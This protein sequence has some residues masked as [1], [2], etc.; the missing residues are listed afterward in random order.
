MKPH[1]VI[2]SCLLIFSLVL[3]GCA[4][5][6]TVVKDFKEFDPTACLNYDT[7]F[8]EYASNYTLKVPPEWQCGW[9]G[10]SGVFGLVLSSNDIVSAF[11][12][13]DSSGALTL[14]FLSEYSGQELTTLFSPR[15]ATGKIV[16]E[17]ELTTINGQEAATIAYT[18]GSQTIIE[19]VVAKEDV[20]LSVI[21]SFPSDKERQFRPFVEGIIS[22]VEV[23]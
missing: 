7:A 2:L 5:A 12:L 17:A 20:F 23:K 1:F 18:E 16:E 3:S 21:G 22:T 9:F 8:E 10:D 19:A 13:Q 14:I 11:S 15:A 6:E 4:S